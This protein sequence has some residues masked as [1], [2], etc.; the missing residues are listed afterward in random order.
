MIITGAARMA[1]ALRELEEP[2]SRARRQELIAAVV[3]FAEERQRRASAQKIIDS[4][5]A[6]YASGMY[7]AGMR[8]AAFLT[9]PEISQGWETQ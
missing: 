9:S 4:L 2:G 5:E 6:Q 3:H 1:D 8:R 7:E